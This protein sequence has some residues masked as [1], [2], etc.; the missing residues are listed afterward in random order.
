MGTCEDTLETLGNR[1]KYSLVFLKMNSEKELAWFIF[2]IKMGLCLI[3]KH[4]MADV[5]SLIKQSTGLAK[6]TGQ[7]QGRSS[8]L[9]SPP[10][11]EARTSSG[12]AKGSLWHQ[13]W[14]A[15]TVKKS[16]LWKIRI[17][18]AKACRLAMAL[19]QHHPAGQVL[20]AA[21]SPLGTGSDY[22]PASHKEL[23]L[24]VWRFKVSCI[25]LS[26]GWNQN[27]WFNDALFHSSNQFMILSE[28]ILE[29]W[30]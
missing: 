6:A 25:W 14:E 5:T 3:L 15:E 17:E 22:C 9:P 8:E 21:F 4:W 13:A 18:H 2:Q 11:K 1:W 23:R 19:S 26:V 29:F 27:C 24:T 10:P 30:S 12:K 16:F 7:R 28:S 20:I